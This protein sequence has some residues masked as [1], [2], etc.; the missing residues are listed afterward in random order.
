MDALLEGVIEIGPRAP[1]EAE[2]KLPDRLGDVEEPLHA[3]AEELVEKAG[4]PDG[5]AFAHAD[6][7][8]VFRADHLDVKRRQL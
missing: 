3:N 6:D 2:A 5:R 4:E 1:K 7:S 8:D